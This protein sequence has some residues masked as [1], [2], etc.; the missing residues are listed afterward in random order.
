MEPRLRSG[1]RGEGFLGPPARQL[2]GSPTFL[3]H[4]PPAAG[5]AGALDAL[6]APEACQP[7]SP[8]ALIGVGCPSGRSQPLFLGPWLM[9]PVC[10]TGKVSRGRW[11]WRRGVFRP[12]L[13]RHVAPAVSWVTEVTEKVRPGGRE[14]ADGNWSRGVPGGQDSAYSPSGPPLCSEPAPCAGGPG[15]TCMPPKR[16][17][18]LVLGWAQGRLL[19]PGWSGPGTATGSGAPSQAGVSG[20]L[21]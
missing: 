14:G 10:E 17:V 5:C 9:S 20:P 16:R 13:P 18:C 19:C 3:S 4:L 7:C 21:R 11:N 6:Y 12:R 8:T 2:L 1:G 15:G